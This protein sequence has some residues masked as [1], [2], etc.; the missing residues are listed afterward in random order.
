MQKINTFCIYFTKNIKTLYN[1]TV[2]CL[3]LSMVSIEKSEAFVNFSVSTTVRKLMEHFKMSEADLCRGVSLPQTTINRL[4]TGQTCDPRI[5]TLTILAQFFNVSLDQI[6]GKEKL[7]L[8]PSYP[9]TKGSTIPVIKWPHLQDWLSSQSHFEDNF[10]NFIKTEKVLSSGSFAVKTPVACESVLGKDSLLIMNRF[11]NSEAALEGQIML[12]E[13][14]PGQY[15]LRQILQEG[16]T[17]YL[18][19]LFLPFEIS[20]AESRNVFHASVVE[21]RTDRFTV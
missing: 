21:A 8:N 11:H 13:L 16:T 6:I 3:L 7:V 19:R 15:G 17:Y 12:I 1:Y 14:S 4:L 9:Q 20:K 2:F 18:K 10:E 5:S